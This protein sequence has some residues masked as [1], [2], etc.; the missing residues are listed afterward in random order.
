MISKLLLLIFLICILSCNVATSPDYEYFSNNNSP[1]FLHNSPSSDSIPVLD[2]YL[3]QY[4]IYFLGETHG[5]ADALE[6]EGYLLQYL[7]YKKGCRYSLPESGL[8]NTYFINKFLET[9]ELELLKSLQFELRKSTSGSEEWLNFYV[10][11]R[12][13]N[14]TKAPSERIKV[15]GIDIEFQWRMVIRFFQDIVDS[16]SIPEQLSEV[17]TAINAKP[18]DSYSHRSEFMDLFTVIEQS[19]E[20][21]ESQWEEFLEV[22]TYLLFEQIIRN[23]RASCI[24]LNYDL[25]TDEGS[26]YREN[27]MLENFRYYYNSIE[28]STPIFL[29]RFGANH[30]YQTK[31]DDDHIK[32]AGLINND[33]NLGLNE[34]VLSINPIFVN[35][36]RMNK[37]SFHSEPAPSNP[38]LLGLFYPHATAQYTLFDISGAD[39]EIVNNDMFQ[40]VLLFKNARAA[41]KKEEYRIEN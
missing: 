10:K 24:A 21:Q 29:G 41:Y 1:I 28:N 15:C 23:Y 4:D 33:K 18:W 37:H 19:L 16:N 7:Y 39:S 2:N 36:Y 30:I 13:F 38:Y 25:S 34:K 5:I 35:S 6:M 12:E 27:Q 26:Q 8:A 31:K 17:V 14:L 22:D 40:S 32:I 3:D 9:G 11:L 20:N